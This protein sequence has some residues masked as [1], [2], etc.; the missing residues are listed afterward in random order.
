MDTQHLLVHS[1]RGRPQGRLVLALALVL[2]MESEWEG[3]EGEEKATEG[4]EKV[5]EGEEWQVWTYL[6]ESDVSAR[7]LPCPQHPIQTVNRP[8]EHRLD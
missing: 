8:G 6:M 1:S 7:R 4:E 3:M 2:G 5:T